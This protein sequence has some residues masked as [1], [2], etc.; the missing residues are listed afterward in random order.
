MGQ[1]IW[2]R[3][4]EYL[5]ARGSPN[6][7][8]PK[9]RIRLH[10][11]YSDRERYRSMIEEW[12]T[13]IL[14]D[15]EN[16]RKVQVFLDDMQKPFNFLKITQSEDGPDLNDEDIEDLEEQAEGDNRYHK[17][18]KELEKQFDQAAEKVAMQV[19][20][21]H[22]PWRGISYVAVVV[23]MLLVFLTQ[24]HRTDFVT[25]T[26]CVLGFLF[27]HHPQNENVRRRDFR[28]VVAFIFV[29]LVYYQQLFLK[30]TLRINKMM[31]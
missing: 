16:L 5:D 30:Q 7:D 2:I 25:L 13:E 15:L 4:D 10:Y 18:E 21:R 14:K 26:A 23:Q 12:Q 31:A 6:E 3:Q 17:E 28:L 11:S 9:L 1:D 19:G 29:S 22:I 27:L 24:Y 8:C 20:Y